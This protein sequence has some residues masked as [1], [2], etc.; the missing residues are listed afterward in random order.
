MPLPNYQVRAVGCDYRASQDEIYSALK[1]ATDPLSRAWEKLQSAKRIAIKFNQDWKV[2][3]RIFEGHH[4][5]HV[6]KQT[7]RALLRLLRERTT[8]KL[9][10]VDV[11]VFK[12]WYVPPPE[13]TTW[14][15][16]VF[17]EYDVEYVD[18]NQPPI[19]S[20]AVPGGGLMFA[21]YFLP[22]IG[23]AHV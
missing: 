2:A 10:C 13:N 11:S 4:Q 20:Y 8:A 22:E 12:T 6:S 15:T 23:R 7:A 19:R 5:E 3:P 9:V 14:L 16:D 18:W 17:Q 1:R 21:H